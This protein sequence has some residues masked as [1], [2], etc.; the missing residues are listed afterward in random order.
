MRLLVVLAFMLSL[1][2]FSR[3]SAAQYLCS[4]NNSLGSD[5]TM[6]NAAV[7][8]GYLVI[9][10]L[11]AK[12]FDSLDIATTAQVEF[13]IDAD[14][15]LDTGDMRPGALRGV[16]HR[17]NCVAGMITSCSLYRLPSSPYGA[18]EKLGVSV[19]SSLTSNGYGLRVAIPALTEASDVFAFSH[20]RTRALSSGTGNGDR[21]PEAGFYDTATGNVK[22]PD[23]EGI[24]AQIDDA[25]GPALM[26]WKVETFGDQFRIMAGYK[27]LIN[28]FSLN[29]A[30]RFELDTDRSLA[31]GLVHTPFLRQSPFNEIPT[32]GWDVAIQIQGGSQGGSDPTPF[33]LD[34]GK[35]SIYSQPPRSYAFPYGFPFG[36]KYNDGRWYVKDNILVLEGSLSMLDPRTWSPTSVTRIPAD[37]KLVG[38]FFTTAGT[39]VTDMIPKN[40][41]AWDTAS[42]T[43]VPAIQWTGSRV[44]GTASAGEVAGQWDLTHVDAQI[45]GQNLVVRGTVARIDPS[46]R[47]THYILYLDTDANSATGETASGGG[48]PIGADY[49]VLVSPSDQYAFIDY[50]T[51]LARAGGGQEGHDSWLNIRYSDSY[52]SSGNI[53]LTCPLSSIGNPG[54]SVKL[55][56]GTIAIYN[57]VP[58]IQDTA[59]A[60]V[61]LEVTAPQPRTLT[62]AIAGEGSV[63]SNPPGIA[64]AAG[65][66]ALCSHSF[67]NGTEVTITPTPGADY[68]FENWS[69][70]CTSIRDNNCVVS[71]TADKSVKAT[72][73]P[74][75]KVRVLGL[76]GFGSLQSAY[77]AAA[78][79]S[80][81]QARAV[82][83]LGN[84][85]LG[86]GKSV[87][88][89]GGYDS[90]YLD[91]SGRLTTL[92]GTM[93]IRSGSI[94]VKNF[95]IR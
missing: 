32:W 89:E 43:V 25:T 33:Y 93:R 21:C 71:L 34:F 50:T 5:L 55:Y 20:G 60:D 42:K 36:E 61:A 41:A 4:T 3:Q 73:T 8:D 56:L 15:N 91:N 19:S 75:P 14:Q 82:E 76:G 62:V 53:I 83:L 54:T 35:Q 9:D 70:G 87:L 65:S 94:K 48:T 66:A 37:G 88:F 2:V 39:E 28:L 18:E 92:D 27:S 17:I 38:R 1:L 51:T 58:T 44:S 52:L 74:S 81:I 40:E 10:V 49:M 46:W 67:V 84:F 64:C 24:E 47:D 22:V 26:G 6:L 13:F 57:G 30:G 69:G 29:F 23:T 16:D 86:K 31:T 77:D 63:H 80:A 59:P 90:G 11:G 79:V 85:V 12:P 72:F 45:E 7:T 95:R 78:Q 68:L